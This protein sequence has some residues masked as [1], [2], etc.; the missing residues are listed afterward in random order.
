MSIL[1][2][3]AP[4]RQTYDQL[5]AVGQNPF[6][7]VFDEMFSPTEGLH[8]GRRTILL[9]TN[10]YLG[11]TFDQECIE[12]SV[13]VLRQ[14]GT[15]TTG[16]RIANGSYSGH[17][18]LETDLAAYF[19]SLSWRASVDPELAMRVASR[20]Q[21]RLGLSYQHSVRDAQWY[22]NTTDAEGVTHYT[23]ARLNQHV[24]AVTTRLDI[25]ATRTLSLQLYASPFVATG[26]ESTASS[27][28][29]QTRSSQAWA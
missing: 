3:F 22:G 27:G 8:K 26:I 20:L 16:S 12:A 11:L 24:A 5:R 9:G 23:F 10:N 6:E 14:Q 4:L 25:T 15:G 28:A 21:A 17:R 13:D 18:Q 1:N 29:W 19:K 2:K 7:M